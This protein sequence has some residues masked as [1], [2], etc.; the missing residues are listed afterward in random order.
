MESDNTSDAH[1]QFI[2]LGLAAKRVL[3]QIAAPRSWQIKAGISPFAL[4]MV[5]PVDAD[6]RDQ[7]DR[8]RGRHEKTQMP[9]GLPPATKKEF[10]G[11]FGRPKVPPKMA[12]KP[13]RRE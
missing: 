9:H 10:R 4:Q 6:A 1:T 12:G 13:S 8:W 5:D 7:D 3:R 11:S 2:P